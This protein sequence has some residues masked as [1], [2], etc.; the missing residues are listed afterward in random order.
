[1]SDSARGALLKH[2]RWIEGHADVWAIFRD[3]TALRHVVAGL[4]EPFRNSDLTA[5]CGIE[6]RGFLLGGAAA[7][8]LGVGFVPVRKREGLFPGDK[9]TAAADPDYRQQSH[10]LRVQRSSL[11]SRDR[12]LLVDDWIET[13]NQALTA[14]QL[15]E[16]CGSTWV[17]CSVLVD[18]LRDDR[19]S[20]L[21]TVMSL[22]RADELPVW[23][24]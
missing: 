4:V 20:A 18:Q 17:G 9:I 8:E 3:A 21:G 2:F 24:G 14:R 10:T 19:R 1:M 7:V 15:V 6:S 22:V 5:I 16:Q 12:V 13:G 23:T 11:G